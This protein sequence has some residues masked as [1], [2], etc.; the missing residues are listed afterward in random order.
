MF[1]NTYTT[2]YDPEVDEFEGEFE[3]SFEDSFEGAFESSE[4]AYEFESAE[5]PLDEVEE[6]ELAAEL[7]E[8]TSDE[9]LDQFLGK[10]FKK[11]WGGIKKVAKPLG[12]V[13]KGVAKVAL[14]IAGKVAGGFFGGPAGAMIGGK[15][16]SV[17][18][19]VFGAEL[20]SMSPEDQSFEVARRFVRLAAGSAARAGRMP[21]GRDPMATAR[22]AVRAAARRY[23]P[24]LSRPKKRRPRRGS[25]G[26]A[27][28]GQPAVEEPSEDSGTWVRRGRSIVILNCR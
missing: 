1:E 27:V 18:S 12:R 13:L 11:V 23:A 5:S 3:D 24:G 17:A 16:G 25:F 19:K 15:L 26:P 4:T 6:M 22:G 20:E 10:V 2:E 21:A 9:E 28:L 8:V 7:L 14:P